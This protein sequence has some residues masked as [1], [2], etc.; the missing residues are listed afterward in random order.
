MRR[1]NMDSIEA[2]LIKILNQNITAKKIDHIEADEKLEALGI[3]SITFIKIIVVLE[4]EFG[5]EFDDEDLDV[6]V[7]SSLKSLITYI[8]EKII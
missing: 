1:K 4:K 5:I 2:T 7:F 8:K 3:N 6:N